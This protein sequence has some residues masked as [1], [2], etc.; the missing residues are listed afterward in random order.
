MRL[1]DITSRIPLVRKTAALLLAVTLAACSAN[2]KLAS[3]A[4]DDSTSSSSSSSSSSSGSTKPGG[5]TSGSE[6]TTSP[7]PIVKVTVSPQV[8]QP[9]QS[10][11]ITW[12]A[13]AAT[14]CT[15]SGA[16]SGSEPVSNATGV[17]TGM[18]NAAGTYTY[19][20]TCTGAGG[21]GS[22]SEQVFVGA[23]N[24]PT[25]NLQLSP[26]AIQPGDSAT[27]TW[28]STNSTSCSASGG[29]GSDGWGGTVATQNT[30]GFNTGAVTTAGQYS[31]TLTC[32]GPGGTGSASQILA[33][34]SS[35]PPAPPSM[36]FNAQPTLLAPGGSS[37]LTWTV[38]N[39]MS[40]T[41]SGG[42]GS[43][44]WN[45]S[46]PLTSSGTPV[47]PIS[48]AGS[49]TYTLTCTGSG[50]TNS[51]SV[52]VL[53]SSGSTVPAVS[54]DM[55]VSPSTITAG[56]S[57]VLSW[58]SSNASSCVASGSWGGSQP[59]TGSAVSTG[60]LST[61]AVYSYTLDCTGAGG[62]SSSTATLTVNPAAAAV[63]SFAANPTAIQA[64]QSTSLAWA[65]TGA[66][67]C[68]AG[69]GT[70][71]DGWTGTEP[72]SSS[73]A[74][75]GPI[76][77]AGVY[78]YSLTCTGPGGTSS[79]SSV[80]VT[81][82]AGSIIPL[83]TVT[84][85]VA[86]PTTIQVGQSTTFTWA[87]I[88]ASSCTATG[89]SGSDSWS[90]AEPVASLATVIGPL[91]TAGT[92]T[93][94]LTCSGP[95]GTS[96]ASTVTITVGAATPA[97]Q[98]GVFLA[99]P[100]S[101]QTGQSTTL[102]WATVNASSCSATG[103]TG[104]DGWAGSSEPPA[105]LGTA[106]GPFT[107]AGTYTYS[108][109]CTGV[110][111]TSAP[112]SVT[113]TVT[114]LPPPAAITSFTVTPSAIQTG[115]SLSLAWTTTNATSCTAT[116]GT[117]TDGWTIVIPRAT[118]STGTSIGPVIATGSV[119]YTLTCTGT[120]G[121]SAPSTVTVTVS[122]ATPPASI[123]G[124]TAS[125]TT[126]T[127]GGTTTLSW[128]SANAL[129]CAGTGGSLLDGWAGVQPTSSA[130]VTVGPIAIAG[131]YTYSL[132][133][134]G[135]G[136]VSQASTAVVTVVAPTPPAAVTS[137]IATPSTLTAGQSTVLSWSSTNATSCLASGGSG[138]DN[139]S[140]AESTNNAALIVGPIA[141]AGTYTYTLSCTGP[142]GTGTAGSARVTVN[143]APVGAP[144]ISLTVNNASS[145]N[146][147][148]G[149]SL[150]LVWSATNATACTAGGGTGS[151]GWGGT[152]ATSDIGKSIGPISVPGIYT[153]TLSCTGA[154]GTGNGS[155]TVT[156]LSSTAM[157]CGIS[158]PTMALL[159]PTASATGGVNGLCLLGCG[160]SNLSNVTDSNV[161]NYATIS[162]AVGVAASGYVRV[163]DSTTTFPAGRQ[164]GFLVADPSALLSL[165]LLQNVSVRTLLNGT[166]Q[167]TAT[168]GNLLT[169][170]ALGLLNNPNEGFVGFTTSL[171]FNAVEVDL[172]Q[173]AS[174]LGTLSVYDACVGLQ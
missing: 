119:P 40:C 8:I 95:G 23:V 92:Y 173:L 6:G 36:T 121:T 162:I 42:S 137:L 104:S 109:I 7:A 128:T 1:I 122:A 20:L 66:T 132:I 169:L 80:T 120:G 19:A 131:T 170:Q 52:N 10:A 56:Q 48:T 163:T 77:T 25:V 89:G 3:P 4:S 45:G 18:L 114:S 143:P 146:I 26:A 75:L 157:S 54:V 116:G 74:S 12:S 159:A 61:A 134:T 68:T 31:Y 83:P 51:Q 97:P 96:S 67:A 81:V 171:P 107:T 24:A 154:G 118:S 22:A 172:G 113:V 158:T 91:N 167:E 93:Y 55:S 34:A 28:S 72:T 2:G 112:L 32:T 62:S 140:G 60:T 141:T 27:L 65:T 5:T 101:V 130:G 142:G 145:A 110:G 102:T 39:A 174:V 150:T 148:P 47:G 123:S 76:N 108:L 144:V 85:F 99:T 14:A 90:G 139:W 147:Q 126:I 84:T 106:I 152:I 43:D 166:V 37:S 82:T 149:Q 33:V 161:N 53:V 64:G 63:T 115:Q 165:T 125:P 69:G 58:T 94:A 136:G 153:Y 103:G 78:T 57:A 38:V 30:T 168:T 105:S 41:A 100:S 17:S 88:N 117:L 11:T 151:D 29:T 71:S 70:G 155:V 124:F 16:W 73:S 35:A 21:S 135:L 164:A 44:G 127:T 9:G 50:G 138:A 15:A 133:C 129:T 79:P 13:T 111:G 86:V 156:V 59:T 46:K 87:A 98:I 49:Y 160:V